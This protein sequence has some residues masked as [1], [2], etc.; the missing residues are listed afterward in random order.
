MANFKFHQHT[1]DTDKFH[2]MRKDFRNLTNVSFS[3]KY[4]MSLNEVRA[5][6]RA[7]GLRKNAEHCRRIRSQNASVRHATLC[8]SDGIAFHRLEIRVLPRGENLCDLARQSMSMACGKSFRPR[9]IFYARPTCHD[10]L[11][12]SVRDQKV[13]KHESRKQ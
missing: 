6:A 2:K 9:A 4:R 1:R 11:A 7:E 10:C 3:K 13:K 5:W 12:R 8:A